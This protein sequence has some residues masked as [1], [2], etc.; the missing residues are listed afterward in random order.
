MADA[1]LLLAMFVG[2]ALAF[3]FWLNARLRRISLERLLANQLPA[4]VVADT[5]PK[6][7]SY[8]R[9]HRLL[10]WLCGLLLAVGLH[11]LVG[12]QPIYC[13]AGA[14]VVALIGSLIEQ[15]IAKR[16]TR[17]WKCNWPMLLT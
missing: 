12:L 1:V 14:I 4:E 7:R 9:R 8:L 5:E 17:A 11:Y 15:M 2:S 6:Q 16:N 3:Y 10:P 13:A